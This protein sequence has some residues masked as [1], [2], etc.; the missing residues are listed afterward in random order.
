MHYNIMVLLFLILSITQQ[1]YLDQLAVKGPNPMH[2]IIA[3]YKRWNY[4]DYS[5]H[6]IL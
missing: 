3:L 5:K 1:Q 2:Q 6:K 4:L